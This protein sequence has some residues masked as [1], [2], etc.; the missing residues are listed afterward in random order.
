MS[1]KQPIPLPAEACLETPYPSIRKGGTLIHPGV[2]D[3]KVH[4]SKLS[5]PDSYRPQ[6]CHTCQSEVL[7]LHDRRERKLKNDGLVLITTVLRYRC[8]NPRCQARWQVLPQLIP[9]AGC[10]HG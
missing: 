6:C 2:V 1:Q 4:E 7:H 8:I 5:D 9:K 10:S 3:L